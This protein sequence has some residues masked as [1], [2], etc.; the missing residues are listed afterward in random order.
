MLKLCQT[1]DI[2]HF[3]TGGIGR[4]P[5]SHRRAADATI[6]PDAM[7]RHRHKRF[8]GGWLGGV[9]FRWSSGREPVFGPWIG[10]VAIAADFQK[11][12]LILGGEL[13]RP[14]ELGTFPRVELGNDPPRR[15][16]VIE[17]ER[18]AVV[19]GGD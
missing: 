11:A 3:M 18:L 6:T 12:R 1:H 4:W 9:G 10:G 2:K 15:P 5:M 13:D 7:E 8:N 16:A 19:F 14:N 17:R